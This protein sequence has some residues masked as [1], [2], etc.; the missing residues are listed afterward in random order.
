MVVSLGGDASQRRH[1]KNVPRSRRGGSCARPNANGVCALG[2]DASQ[3]RRGKNVP[4]VVG[5]GLVP[6]RTPMGC[7]H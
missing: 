7:A 4:E 1:A 5:A 6:V 3:R 2:G